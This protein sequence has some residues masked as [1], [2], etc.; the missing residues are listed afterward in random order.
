[1]YLPPYIVLIS[2]IL[3]YERI[4]VNRETLDNSFSIQESLK[5][6]KSILVGD[7]EQQRKNV[8]TLE[9][10]LAE[11]KMKN[12]FQLFEADDVEK[13]I[14]IKIAQTNFNIDQ[15]ILENLVKRTNDE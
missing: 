6:R 14:E 13:E 7:I 9:R 8:R 15:E 2:F 3:L 1:M 11:Y 4:P 10:K 12:N 5:A